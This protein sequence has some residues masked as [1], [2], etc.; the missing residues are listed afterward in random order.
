MIFIQNIKSSVSDT[1]ISSGGFLSIRKVYGFHSISVV[2]YYHKNEYYHL[3]NVPGQEG[4]SLIRNVYLRK[5]RE[6]QIK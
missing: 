1:I 3:H 2:K 6:K 4:V 5:L